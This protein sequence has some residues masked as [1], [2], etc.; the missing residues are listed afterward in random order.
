M[1][2]PNRT[3]EHISR[4]Q[5]APVHFGAQTRAAPG[6]ISSDIVAVWAM[7]SLEPLVGLQKP[8]RPPGERTRPTALQP[9][10][11]QPWSIFSGP[12]VLPKLRQSRR[13]GTRALPSQ[14][15]LPQFANESWAGRSLVSNREEGRRAQTAKVGSIAAGSIES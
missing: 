6:L 5:S 8:R 1:W 3:R 15:L 9:L 13:L 4:S 10:K 12:P 11:Q 2:F 7:S 14:V